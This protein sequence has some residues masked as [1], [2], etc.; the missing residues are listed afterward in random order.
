MLTKETF[1]WYEC[2]INGAPNLWVQ[3]KAITLSDGTTQPLSLSTRSVHEH[4]DHEA[5]AAV[6]A[7]RENERKLMRKETSARAPWWLAWPLQAGAMLVFCAL[8]VAFGLFIVAFAALTALIEV[9]CAI[10]R[11]LRWVLC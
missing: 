1:T 3:P 11:G 7:I 4:D 9:A 8:C 6:E 10:A 5:D 2:Y